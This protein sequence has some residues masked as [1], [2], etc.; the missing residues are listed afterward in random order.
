MLQQTSDAIKLAVLGS[1]TT[2]PSG[3]PIASLAARARVARLEREAAELAE[4]LGQSGGAP[5]DRRRDDIEGRL[6]LTR[7]NLILARGSLEPSAKPVS[8]SAALF[9]GMDRSAPAGEQAAT[10]A[11]TSLHVGRS[12]I[13]D[14][15]SSD[16]CAPTGSTGPGIWNVW[17]DGRAIGATDA[18]AR[19][20]GLGFIG[21]AGAD[22]KVQPWLTLGLTVGAETFETKLGTGGLRMGERG[23][24]AIPYLGVRLD[25][26]IFV[27]A[28]VGASRLSYDTAPAV[29]ITGQFDAWRFLTGGALTGV[30]REQAWRFQPSISVAYASETQS[31]YANSANTAVASQIVQYGRLS[32]GPEIGYRFTF[33][34]ES[35]WSVEPFVMMGANY[36]FATDTTALF[37][38]QQAGMRGQ[39]S[40]TAGFG[41]QVQNANG[42]YGRAELRYESI[43]I[44][45]L[46]VW[47]GILRGGWNF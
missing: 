41:M 7:R 6:A 1:F 3:S 27:S 16:E 12:S 33:D 38:T 29:G 45:G 13:Q 11:P 21:N 31:A 22:Y 37:N 19:Q 20:S 43:G 44:A 26:N 9:P 18:I 35:S 30:W 14:A 17:L 15:C 34:G 25:P 46:D 4:E 42:L 2:T 47:V 40:G 10:S 5:G 28:Y 24:S 23:L 32:A 39:G 8:A 36:T